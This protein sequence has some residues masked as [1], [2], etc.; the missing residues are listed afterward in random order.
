VTTDGDLDP[1]T[2]SVVGPATYGS[3]YW[4]SNTQTFIYIA[5]NSYTG[6]DSFTVKA[7][8]G[9]L[10][11]NIRTIN[12]NVT[13]QAPVIA[14][15]ATVDV[16]HSLPTR[17]SSDLVTTDGDL[18]ALSYSVVGPAT[19]GSAYWDSTSQTFIYAAS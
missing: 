19:Y 5:S 9:A 6:P 16:L 8:D 1:L 14:T 7:N 2:Y 3:A 12:I 18:D 10:D 11:S 13:D 15:I 17:R 4:D